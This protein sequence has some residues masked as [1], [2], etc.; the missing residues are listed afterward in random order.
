MTFTHSPGFSGSSGSLPSAASASALSHPAFASSATS[1]DDRRSAAVLDVA[2]QLRR[3]ENL[4]DQTFAVGGDLARA[5]VEARTSHEV[6]AVVGHKVFQAVA[7]AQLAVTQAR[8]HAVS[9]HR[10]LDR[11]AEAL[12][13][14]PALFGDTTKPAI[15]LV[16]E[17]RMPA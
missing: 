8:G 15:A 17:P 4:L 3:F 13:I 14:D 11:V 16:D 7:E 9:G 12:R 1:S 5:L 2:D 6:S 10:L